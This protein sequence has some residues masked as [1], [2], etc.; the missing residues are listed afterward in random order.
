[1]NAPHINPLAQVR[2]Q[3]N[4]DLDAI[5][6]PIPQAKY[7]VD[8]MFADLEWQLSRY[9]DDWGG[10]NLDPDYQ[11]G[12]VWSSAQQREFIEGILRDT[13]GESQLIIQFNVPHWTIDTVETD[14]PR[15]MQIV[16]GLQRLTA[17]RKFIAGEIEPFGLTHKDLAG[18]SYSLRLSRYRFRFAIHDFSRRADLLTFYLNINAGGTPHSAEEI[19]RVRA[20]LIAAQ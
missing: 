3:L 20:L 17:V 7:T 1:M 2:S 9:A 16:D 6:Q 19:N 15:E 18:S 14:L 4:R 12:H 10:L 13:V 8:C 5:I 11:R